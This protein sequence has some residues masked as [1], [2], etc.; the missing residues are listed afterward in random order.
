MD[1]VIDS[2]KLAILTL[3]TTF[4]YGLLYMT[5]LAYP[6][7]FQAQRGWDPAIGSLPFLSIFVGISISA[8]CTGIFSKTWYAKRWRATQKLNPEDRLPPMIVGSIL[9]PIGV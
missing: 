8:V 6:V 7:A 9:L 1:A 3:Y 4:T 5:F 2:H